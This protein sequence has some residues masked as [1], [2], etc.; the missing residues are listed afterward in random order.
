MVQVV[1]KDEVAENNEAD[2]YVWKIPQTILLI[3]VRFWT[4]TCNVKL[5]N[6]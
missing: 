5:V 4:V 3:I 6:I 1:K 2:L